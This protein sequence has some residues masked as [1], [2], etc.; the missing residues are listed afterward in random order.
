LKI[1]NPALTGISGRYHYLWT[2]TAVIQVATVCRHLPEQLF[3]WPRLPPGTTTSKNSMNVYVL[4]DVE[5]C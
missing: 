1:D 5:D 4:F 3:D 2:S